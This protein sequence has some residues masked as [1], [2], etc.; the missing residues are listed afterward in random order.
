MHCFKKVVF[1]FDPDTVDGVPIYD[2]AADRHTAYLNRGIELVVV[3]GEIVL[4]GDTP[5]GA[6]PGQVLR[7]NA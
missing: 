2:P 5:T 7:L 3:N 6:L 4:E 1:V